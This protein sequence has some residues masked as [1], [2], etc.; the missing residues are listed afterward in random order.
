MR[1]IQF[2]ML[3]GVLAGFAATVTTAGASDDPIQ[4]RQAIMKSVGG[5]AG[6][7]GE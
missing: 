4:S 6:L 7:A 5:A 1:K 3:A 2:A